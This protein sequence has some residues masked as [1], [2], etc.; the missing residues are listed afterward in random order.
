MRP[1]FRQDRDVLSKNPVTRTRTWRVEDPE[2]ASSGGPFSLVTFSYSGHPALRPSGRLRRSH[3]LLRMRGQARE[4]NPA[5]GR[6]AEARG[7]RASWRTT[8]Q[9]NT[10]ALDPGLRRDDELK[11][12]AGTKE[13]GARSESLEASRLQKKSPQ[14]FFLRATCSPSSDNCN[15]SNSGKSLSNFSISSRN[16]CTSSNFRYTEAKRTY[17]T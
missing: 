16:A 8:R 1:V 9:L 17:A 11:D 13:P 15:A 14:D 12:R 10:E 2:G 4:S 6:R 7:R 5:S 3:A